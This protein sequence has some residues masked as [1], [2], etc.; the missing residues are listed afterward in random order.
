MVLTK[1]VTFLRD[2]APPKV[3]PD[4]LARA[5]AYERRVEDLFPGGGG[6][7][8]DDDKKDDDKTD[9][10]GGKARQNVLQRAQTTIS[11]R[12]GSRGAAA[13]P[14][15]VQTH[16]TENEVTRSGSSTCVTRSVGDYDSSRTLVPYPDLVVKVFGGEGEEKEEG[17]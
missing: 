13:G 14:P 8:D 15:V 5:F 3:R 4:L 11:R 10:R 17:V 2:S 12:R 16:W 1:S 6:L 7:D 9:T